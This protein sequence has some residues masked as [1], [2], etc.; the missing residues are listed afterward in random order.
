MPAID[1]PVLGP[2][3]KD[4]LEMLHLYRKT[5]GASEEAWKGSFKV[6]AADII[7]DRKQRVDIL[8]RS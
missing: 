1:H 3:L 8:V 5:K 4:I 7:A 2:I 6:A